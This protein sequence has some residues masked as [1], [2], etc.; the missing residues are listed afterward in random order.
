MAK[1]KYDEARLKKLLEKYFVGVERIAIP[2]CN[3]IEYEVPRLKEYPEEVQK[4]LPPGTK[5]RDIFK[6]N[7]ADEILGYFDK[8]GTC[9][10]KPG[11][12]HKLPEVYDPQNGQYLGQQPTK[13]RTE[14]L[15]QVYCEIGFFPNK[16]NI[17]ALDCD[18]LDKDGHKQ[19][20]SVYRDRI[21]AMAKSNSPGKFHYYIPFR[22]D[23]PKPIWF[24]RNKQ[25]GEFGYESRYICFH[26]KFEMYKVL[27]RIDAFLEGRLKKTFLTST[28]YDSL[29]LN[30]EE[31]KRR[32]DNSK[33]WL[34]DEIKQ[35]AE[36]GELNENGS[37]AI[38]CPVPTHTDNNASAYVYL[39][40]GNISCDTCGGHVG[41]IKEYAMKHGGS[42]DGAGRN[43]MP[44][45][46]VIDHEEV[47]KGNERD[48][49]ALELMDSGDIAYFRGR[50]HLLDRSTGLW[51]QHEDGNNVAKMLIDSVATLRIG[52][53]SGCTSG[54]VI[55][56]LKTVLQGKEIDKLARREGFPC[57]I[58]ING[59]EKPRMITRFRHVIS[60]KIQLYTDDIKPEDY[61]I[62][63][64]LLGKGLG[65]T[66]D[67][68]DTLADN[69]SN[70]AHTPTHRLYDM[71][72]GID[73]DDTPKDR[74]GQLEWPID[75]YW[76]FINQL[77]RT[78]LGIPVNETVWI[79]GKSGCG[80]GTITQTIQEWMGANFISK[81]VD[82][83]MNSNF[84]LDGIQY[85][86]VLNI[87]EHLT[88]AMARK[89]LDLTDSD[90][91]EIDIKYSSPIRIKWN[92]MVILTGTE[93]PVF[94]NEGEERRAVVYYMDKGVER[95]AKDTVKEIKDRTIA[96]SS[97]AM[98]LDVFA[99]Y[100]ELGA[101]ARTKPSSLT[102]NTEDKLGKNNDPFY[103][104]IEDKLVENTGTT[105]KGSEL[106]KG[107]MEANGYKSRAGVASGLQR[108]I[109]KWMG[110]KIIHFGNRWAVK[111]AKIFEELPE[112]EQYEYRR[113]KKKIRNSK[114]KE[115]DKYLD[116]ENFDN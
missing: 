41:W 10:Y 3:K 110:L 20:R 1:M 96:E 37:T 78:N 29:I 35:L 43:E 57:W 2:T 99:D 64:E 22:G 56:T 32:S 51:K 61:I 81:K 34:L 28:D 72:T 79:I 68:L 30:P 77:K 53:C 25:A 100:I 91:L 36:G 18:H 108:A 58:E 90:D 76:Y 67:D 87:N 48:L 70:D 38:H 17:I 104:Y 16:L 59:L 60:D 45:S 50:Y 23:C 85:S 102:E 103:L 13:Y 12:R 62:E 14:E 94:K 115:V 98:L 49:A 107:F 7:S 83:I 24:F 92:G 66:M 63:R 42:R 93:I 95:G 33:T 54:K 84:G 86:K 75:D 4:N 11:K 6:F 88:V 113:D 21:V 52:L 5:A 47:P 46:C 39:P 9:E 27:Y 44:M 19:F 26:N 82:A 112:D 31:G 116:E 55:N 97:G 8:L 105:V 111:D 114:D 106:V 89:T 71:L 109:D 15:V 80:K 40:E 65:I 73:T 74:R 101:A 69:V